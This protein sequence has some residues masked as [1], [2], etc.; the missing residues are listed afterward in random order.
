MNGNGVDLTPDGVCAEDLLALERRRTLSDY[1]RRRLSMCLLAS[2]GLRML[3][4]LHHD[5]ENLD[6]EPTDE[7]RII[8]QCVATA[9]LRFAPSAERPSRR[10]RL[11]MTL[12]GV[13]A[14]L[15]SLGAAGA[16]Y[17][18]A[19]RFAGP[20]HAPHATAATPGTATNLPL[21]SRARNPEADA[22][23]GDA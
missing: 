19:P 15:V 5:F 2:D 3:R 12:L 8:E 22:P 9:K 16:R 4:Q 1:E 14:L 18:W 20:E 11:R 17:H 10:L 6:P 7:A 21:P 23:P 13:S